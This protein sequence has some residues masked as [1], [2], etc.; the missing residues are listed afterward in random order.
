V[1]IFSIQIRAKLL[2]VAIDSAPHRRIVG[3]FGYE[4]IRNSLSLFSIPLLFVGEDHNSGL[5]D[6]PS[7]LGP[8]WISR[9]C[10]ISWM[11]NFIR[12]YPIVDEAI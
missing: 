10:Q 12:G 9:L 7:S 6:A 4:K 1:R 5:S 11:I 2:P 3:F 8:F